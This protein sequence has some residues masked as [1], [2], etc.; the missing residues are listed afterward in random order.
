MSEYLLFRGIKTCDLIE[1][2][3]WEKMDNIEQYL[4]VK[5]MILNMSDSNDQMTR[6]VSLLLA[7]QNEGIKYSSFFYLNYRKLV[8]LFNDSGKSREYLDRLWPV[9]QLKREY[10]QYKMTMNGKYNFYKNHMD[11]EL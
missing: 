8:E 9:Y 2:I 3:G 10:R 6:M 4:C 11:D 1:P 7:Q 5:N